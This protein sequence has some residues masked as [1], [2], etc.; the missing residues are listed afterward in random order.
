MDPIKLL[1]V[2]HFFVLENT[3][4]NITELV[5]TAFCWW[6][7]TSCYWVLKVF[8]RTQCVHGSSQARDAVIFAESLLVNYLCK[9]CF[10]GQ[11]LSKIEDGPPIVLYAGALLIHERCSYHWRTAAPRE[12]LG[13]TEVEGARDGPAS[14]LRLS[15]DWV[16]VPPPLSFSLLSSLLFSLLH[17]FTTLALPVALP[18]LAL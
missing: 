15:N 17:S 5:K 8:I 10:S 13:E 9:G 6:R 2:M 16:I 12:N 11:E 7:I 3:V 18:T 14:R 4:I 1:H